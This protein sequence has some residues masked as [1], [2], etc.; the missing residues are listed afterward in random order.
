ME[1]N[2]VRR[3]PIFSKIWFFLI[4]FFLSF[5]SIILLSTYYVNSAFAAPST[6]KT[7]KIFIIKEGEALTSIAARLKQEG[8]IR[9]NNVFRLYARFACTGVSLSSPTTLL[10]SYPQEE[11]LAGSIQAGSFKLS[12][13]MDL[14]SLAEK[15]TKGRLDSWTKILEGWRNEEIAIVVEKNYQIKEEDFLK[16]AEIGYMYPDT[17]LFKVN[18]TA[19][20][21]VQKLKTT[22]EEKFTPQLQQEALAQGLSITE[23][24]TLASIIERETRDN[25]DERALVAG[26]LL[27][28]L[29]EGWRLETDATVQFALGYDENE[30]TWWRKNLTEQDLQVNS[31]YNTRRFA[32]LP[33]GPISNPS[34][35]SLKA[36]AL[37][38]ESEYYYYLHDKDGKIHYAQTLAGHNA[39]KEKYLQ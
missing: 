34:I 32:G 24:V 7:E 11:C 25:G 35:S 5:I 27:K 4:L 14:P 17:Y 29:R 19:A 1:N 21:I 10:K 28:R 15:L 33:P 3:K 16:V 2:W 23:T 30:K 26:I 13:N 20:E 12:T 8:L 38:Q 31:P 36:V 37:P 39:N 18:S 22:F 9:D 6:D